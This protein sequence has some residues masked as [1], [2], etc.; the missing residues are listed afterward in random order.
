MLGLGSGGVR[1]SD[2]KSEH[3]LAY[4]VN[5]AEGFNLRRDAFI[6]AAL[7]VRM[8]GP[9]WT[10]VLP[11]FPRLRHWRSTG[12]DEGPIPWRRFFDVERLRETVPVVEWTDDAAVRGRGIDVVWHLLPAER[13]PDDASPLFA[14]Y[15]CPETPAFRRTFERAGDAWTVRGLVGS[16]PLHARMLECRRTFA[17]FTDVAPALRNLP[18]RTILIDRFE[19]LFWDPRL[20]DGGEYWRVRRHMVFAERLRTEAARW[21]QATFGD[22]PYL[23]VHLRRGDF[24]DAHPEVPAIADAAAQIRDAAART[25]LRR[26]FVASDGSPEDIA[27]LRTAID[28]D[29]YEPPAD[30]DWLDGEVAIVDQILAAEARHF[31]G[32]AGSTFTTVIA[33]ERMLRGRSSESAFD[34]LCPG[35]TRDCPQPAPRQVI[36]EGID[37]RP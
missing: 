36:D 13:P 16:T 33:E 10:L 25:G 29:R 30:G 37:R 34:V 8:L 17:S 12:Q 11:P 23:A 3:R 32:T 4:A 18:G 15:P 1:A 14:P 28:F 35:R 19:R 21:R 7:L 26:I 9:G 27:E 20:Y 5:P 22:E 6:R 31:I 24:P 2:A